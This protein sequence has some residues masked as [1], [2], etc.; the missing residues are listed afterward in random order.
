MVGHKVFLLR[1]TSYHS[2]TLT[3]PSCSPSSSRCADTHFTARL[4]FSPAPSPASDS[5]CHVDITCKLIFRFPITYHSFPSTTT[6]SAASLPLTHHS[7]SHIQTMLS[8][9]TDDARKYGRPRTYGQK[10]RRRR[11]QHG[12][13]SQTRKTPISLDRCHWLPTEDDAA[14]SCGANPT[15]FAPLN[16]RQWLL[17]GTSNAA[18]P[19]AKDDDEAEYEE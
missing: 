17:R 8:S 4:L 11:Q 9:M 1:W 19:S 6:I 5:E 15:D 13:C 7:R 2:Q 3:S 14:M 18:D 10:R 16:G 12:H